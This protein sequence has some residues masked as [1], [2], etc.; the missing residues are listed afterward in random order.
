MK[1][2]ASDSFEYNAYFLYTLYYCCNALSD[3]ILYVSLHISFF[4]A[5]TSKSIKNF[6]KVSPAPKD[7]SL[8]RNLFKR[9]LVFDSF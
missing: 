6:L 5:Q 9:D 2:I 8:P 1:K 7:I 3:I 4:S